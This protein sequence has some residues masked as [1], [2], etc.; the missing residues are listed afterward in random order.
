MKKSTLTTLLAVLLVVVSVVWLVREFHHPKSSGHSDGGETPVAKNTSGRPSSNSTMHNRPGPR[1]D[2]K[3][4]HRIRASAG[5]TSNS[6]ARVKTLTPEEGQAIAEAFDVTATLQQ[7]LDEGDDVG[8]L[9][10]ARR[11]VS[12]PNREVRLMTLGALAWLG[13]TAAGDIA[14]FFGDVDEEIRET[15]EEAFWDAL[16]EIDDPSLK[17]EM[18]NISLKSS[19]P[20]LRLEVLNQLIYMP[21]SL[22]FPVIAS[23]LDDADKNVSDLAQ[24]HLEFIS[25]EL[26]T[27]KSDAMAW[28][29]EHKDELQS[30]DSE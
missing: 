11:L 30:F 24:D 18:M 1:S 15:A 7:L 4:L 22:S 26:F 12:H 9:S 25:E 5:S 13:A 21:D 14:T 16:D 2:S 8:A 28:Y 3:P 17:L 23:L 6:N 19:N 20:E 10:E 27:S 29:N